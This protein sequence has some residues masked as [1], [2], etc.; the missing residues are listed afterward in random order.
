MVVVVVV[1]VQVTLILNH[2]WWTAAPQCIAFTLEHHLETRIAA[3]HLL[4]NLYRAL[5]CTPI[6]TV[7]VVGSDLHIAWKPGHAYAR[8]S[9]QLIIPN[10]A[11][12]NFSLLITNL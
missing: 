5:P 4:W 11:C 8:L 12:Y 7:S 9:Y 6:G 3:D 1:A 10:F 2:F